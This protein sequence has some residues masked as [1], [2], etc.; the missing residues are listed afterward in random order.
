MNE[1][2]TVRLVALV[3]WLILALSAFASFRLDWKKSVRMVLIWVVI[4]GGVAVLF[5]LILG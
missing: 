5:G 3:G 2:D 4:F 1:Y